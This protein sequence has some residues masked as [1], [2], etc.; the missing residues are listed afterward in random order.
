MKKN[1]PKI[2][3]VADWL[4]VRGGAE[5]VL[6]SLAR[7]FPEAPVFSTVFVANPF[8]NDFAARVSAPTFLQKLPKSFRK[9]HPFLLPFLPRAIESLDLRE[10]DVILSSSSFVGKGV[11]TNPDQLHICY[12]HTPTRYLWGEWK[13]YLRDFPIPNLLKKILPRLLTKIRIWDFFAAQRPDIF[14]A[15][16]DFIRLQIQKFYRRN[17]EVMVPPVEFSRFFSEGDT[18]K[19]DYFLYFG[20]IVPQ[21]KVDLLIDAFRKM[22][23]KKLVIA[24]TG[25]SEARLREKALGM[26]NIEF[27]GF[28]SD[29]DAPD[30]IR[31]A[32]A[33]LF[34]QKEDA[35]ITALE[36]LSAGTPVIAFG[37]GGALTTLDAKTAIF[38]DEQTPE[39]VITAVGEFEAQN[40]SKFECEARAQMFSREV[41]EQKIRKFVEEKWAEKTS[42]ETPVFP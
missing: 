3:I 14:I 36:A 41:F 15:N 8:S 7:V 27:R 25:R 38:F 2:A 6:E 23:T 18:E 33:L 29:T 39:R 42:A 22:P 37:A 5:S 26:N 30:L 40:F 35:G 34:P 13:S 20:R 21:K 17:A 16:S 19:S 31:R 1:P 4:T 10:F 11:L 28:V 24:G 12:C 32:R 9:N